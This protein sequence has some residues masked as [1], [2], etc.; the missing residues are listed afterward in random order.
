MSTPDLIL[1]T[2]ATGNIGW[3]I[4][5]CLEPSGNSLRLFARDPS[6]LSGFPNA[7]KV[8]GDYT[9]L[10]LSKS[11]TPG[12]DQVA[13]QQIFPGSSVIICSVPRLPM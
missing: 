1:I 12:H 8:K 11:S 9:D 4:A 7:Q 6:K 10:V 2:G 3:W 5:R 13:R